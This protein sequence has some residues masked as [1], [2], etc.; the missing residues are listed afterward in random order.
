MKIFCKYDYRIRLRNTGKMFEFKRNEP[1]EVDNLTAERLILQSKNKIELYT[2]EL[3]TPL[4][5]E[6]E[7]LVDC[8][9]DDIKKSDFYINIPEDV[10]KTATKNKNSILKMMQNFYRPQEIKEGDNNGDKDK[11]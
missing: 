2:E 5:I 11:T 8:S 4:D 3:K 10:K 1:I 9:I 6:L 7:I